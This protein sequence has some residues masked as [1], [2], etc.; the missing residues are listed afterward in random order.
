VY[1]GVQ[2]E[3][4]KPDKHIWGCNTCVGTVTIFSRDAHDFRKHAQSK[5]HDNAVKSKS[6]ALGMQQ[7]Q[8]KAVVKRIAQQIDE[9]G[10]LL[11]I[12]GFMIAT[13]ISLWHFSQVCSKQFKIKITSLYL[14]AA[15][16]STF[17][18]VANSGQYRKHVQYRSRQLHRRICTA[19]LAWITGVSRDPLH[20]EI[21][22]GQPADSHFRASP[23]ANVMRRRFF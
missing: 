9:A 10:K 20:R 11:I 13:G 12:V 15:T 23:T 3:A 4:G 18:I 7:A 2:L 16:V 8:N 21:Q 14:L 19:E 5:Q 6:L 1:Q 22:V 17:S